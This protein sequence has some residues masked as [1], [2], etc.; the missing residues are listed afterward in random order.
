MKKIILFSVIVVLLVGLVSCEK[1]PRPGPPP[2][3]YAISTT[4]FGK[5]SVAPDK[6]SG[7]VLGSSVTFKL[8]PETGYSLYSVKINGVKVEDIYPSTTEIQYVV[9]DVNTNLNIEVT[10][11]ETYNLLISVQ[12]PPW[13]LKAMDIYKEDGTYKYPFTLTKEDKE[14]RTYYH[15]PGGKTETLRIDGTPSF[16]S[17]DWSISQNTLRVESMNYTIIELTATRL[18]YKAPPVKG[19][20]GTYTYAQYTYERN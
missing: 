11:V 1:E 6:L 18:V 4:V 3:T 19:S 20:D 14:G 8:T 17:N 16:S 7:V 15:Y 13:R 9:R 10:F 12:N 5:G 2:V